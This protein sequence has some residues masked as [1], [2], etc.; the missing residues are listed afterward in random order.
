MTLDLRALLM[1]VVFALM[2]SSAFATARIIVADAAPL[3]ALSLRFLISGAL[4]V[5]LALWLGQSIRLTRA[6]WRATVVFGLCQNALYLG[7]NFV[8]MQQIEASL[9]AI[10]ASTM[11]LLV[12]ALRWGFMGQRLRPLG[13]AGLVAGAVG[14]TL[15]MGFRL[16]GGADLFG[17]AICAVGALALAVATLLVRGASGGGNLLMVVGLQMWVGCAAL[18]GISLLTED[19]V[20]RWSWGWGAAFAYQIFVPGLAATLIWFLL[21][22]RIGAV[23]ASTFH[24][25][26][27]F[28]GV[29]IAAMLLGEEVRALDIVGVLVVMAGILAVQISRQAEA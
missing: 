17:V 23:R 22:R 24:F 1:G 19:W 11:P 3:M 21:V 15:I 27:P 12:A 4:A 16:T 8:A 6:Q 10:I 2:W 25:L 26:N 29:S 14:V 9:A 5:L 18:A 28:F 20:L 13:M 7:L